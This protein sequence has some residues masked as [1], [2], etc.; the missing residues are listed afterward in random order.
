MRM[1]LRLTAANVNYNK[2]IA[3]L[4]VKHCSEKTEIFDVVQEKLTAKGH[5]GRSK[6]L[7]KVCKILANNMVVVARKENRFWKINGSLLTVILMIYTYHYLVTGRAVA[8]LIEALRY[9]P[10]GR[11]FD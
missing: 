5:E 3:K 4:W 11:G 8:Q 6:V 9:K 10:E 7:V 2:F 1:V